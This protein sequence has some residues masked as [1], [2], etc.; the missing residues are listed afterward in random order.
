M[1][2]LEK[3][4][5]STPKD[6]WLGTEPTTFLL[7]GDSANHWAT[8]L[9]LF[10]FFTFILSWLPLGSNQHCRRLTR[11]ADSANVGQWFLWS[12]PV[13]SIMEKKKV[14]VFRGR[15]A[16]PTIDTCANAFKDTHRP[17]PLIFLWGRTCCGP[18]F[19]ALY[20]GCI[21]SSD[22]HRPWL[23]CLRAR[24]PRFRPRPR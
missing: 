1:Q 12:Q 8:V 4:A 18:F 5:N 7:S 2:K 20:L 16:P 13:S 11:H 3:H 15:S 10:S 22:T 6:P 21:T 17:Q 9:F 23:V 14:Q 19:G 24:T